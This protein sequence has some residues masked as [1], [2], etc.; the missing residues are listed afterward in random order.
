M[1]FTENRK[2]AIEQILLHSE[3][4]GWQ[5]ELSIQYNVMVLINHL[6]DM[7]LTRYYYII[8]Y[9]TINFLTDSLA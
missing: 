7:N 9:N 6:N 5:M 8:E 3:S 2:S 1:G 4:G